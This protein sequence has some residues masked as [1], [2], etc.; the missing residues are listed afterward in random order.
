MIEY[1]KLYNLTKKFNILYVEDDKKFREKTLE[2]LEYFFT[3]IDTASN[4]EDAYQKYLEY[5]TLNQKNYDMVITDITMP[6]LNGLE[7][8]KKI[9]AY[10]PDQLVIVISAYDSAD[11]LLEFVNIGIEHFLVKPFEL[12]SIF[13][14]LHNASLKLLKKE[15][16]F[17]VN[18]I[19]ELDSTFSWDSKS[20]KLLRDE[21]EVRLTKK[22]ILLMQLFCQKL[23]QVVSLEE[24]YITL[25]G[26]DRHLASPSSLNP[27]I[28]R[29]KKKL[30]LDSIKSIYGFGYRLVV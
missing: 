9:Y 15:E 12:E 11:Y 19:I 20:L 18:Q 3:N 26:D 16:S 28:S 23:N 21:K 17:V 10:N 8:T 7:L 27:I 4:G 13:E 5:F 14:V 22:E 25:W 30:P 24:L 6:K 2:V 29:L 1:S